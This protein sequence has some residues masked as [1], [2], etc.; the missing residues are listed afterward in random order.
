MKHIA[1]LLSLLLLL[2][3]CAAE[4]APDEALPPAPPP[5]TISYD[6]TLFQ[7]NDLTYDLTERNSSINAIMDCAV[8]TPYVIVEGHIGPRE[9]YYGIFNTITKE[10][11]KDI[12][13]SHLIYRD[14]DIETAVYSFENSIY[15]Y[16]GERIGTCNMEEFDLIY[17]L[18]FAE[19]NTRVRVEIIPNGT[20]VSTE[21][22]FDL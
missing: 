20:D 5:D 22:F 7:F 2:T 10:F 4:S 9:G 16:S 19:N 17:E 18:A 1:L 21:Q 13:G 12:I 14:N 15:N 11:E 6:G 8:V 3:G